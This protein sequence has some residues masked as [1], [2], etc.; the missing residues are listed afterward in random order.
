MAAMVDFLID[1]QH[2]EIDAAR[3]KFAVEL[4][5]RAVKARS[6]QLLSMWDAPYCVRPSLMW[7]MQPAVP[8]SSHWYEAATREEA[9]LVMQT[10]LFCGAPTVSIH[11][12]NAAR[13]TETVETFQAVR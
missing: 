4:T 10:M 3:T 7:A 5:R 8:R 6:P 2:A 11:S 12:Y 1:E 9:E 13:T